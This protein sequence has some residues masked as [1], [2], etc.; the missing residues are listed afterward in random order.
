MSNLSLIFDRLQTKVS[1]GEL[2]TEQAN[3]IYEK[4]SEKYAENEA[5]ILQKFVNGEE[6]TKAELDTVRARIAE[7]TGG[8]GD[9][10]GDGKECDGKECD[11]K[12]SGKKG[13]DE[14]DDDDND[15]DDEKE[16]PAELK[17]Y[18]TELKVRAYEMADIGL[19]TE[20][21]KT[22][23]LKVLKEFNL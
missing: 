21:Q 4:A 20:S 17:E 5:E 9:D 1:N 11:D 8:A 18:A 23:I 3:A 16:I 2:T 15:D 12:K 22:K 13:D 14:D 6:L 19:V 7:L 10:K